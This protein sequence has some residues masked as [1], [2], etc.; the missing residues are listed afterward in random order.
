MAQIVTLREDDHVYQKPDGA[1]VDGVSHILRFMSREYYS[2][3]Q[4]YTLDNAADRGTRVHKACEVLDKWGTVEC[5]A[6]I[7]LYVRA[8]VQFRKDHKPKWEGIE[9]S[10]YHP[11]KEYAGT[12]DRIGQIGHELTLVDIKCQE[13]IKKPMVQA[14]VNGY[15]MAWECSGNPMVERLVCLQLKKDGKYKVHEM[16]RDDSVFN[17]CWTL[18]KAL[19]KKPRKKKGESDGNTDE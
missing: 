9:R 15:A 7:E 14:Q 3:I 18:N 1:E 6:D 4:Q 12:I 11:Q 16:D 5:D 10:V 19:K 8:Y 17:A 2:D 13:Q